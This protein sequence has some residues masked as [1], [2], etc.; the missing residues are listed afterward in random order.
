MWKF[1]GFTALLLLQMLL[2]LLLFSLNVREMRMLFFEKERRKAMKRR[3]TVKQTSYK[4]R[5]EN[6]R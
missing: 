2:S 1:Y 5:T 3:G 6:I 4:I